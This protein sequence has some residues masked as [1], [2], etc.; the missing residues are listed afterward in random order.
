MPH[1]LDYE[2]QLSWQRYHHI[3]PDLAKMQN[4]CKYVRK[5]IGKI[6][7]LF[8]VYTCRGCLTCPDVHILPNGRKF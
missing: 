4:L 7:E 5:H 1:V 8:Q 2:V 6:K 3:P